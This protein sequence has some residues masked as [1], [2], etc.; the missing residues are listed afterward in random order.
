[1]LEAGAGDLQACLVPQ[2]ID[3]ELLLQLC[4]GRGQAE[5]VV[6]E[7]RLRGDEGEPV[8]THERNL[9]VGL[10]LQILHDRRVVFDEVRIRPFDQIPEVGVP[11][12]SGDIDAE[13][14]L[15]FVHRIGLDQA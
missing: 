8:R 2:R 5:N 4:L 11:A 15:R 14:R 13:H 12:E 6:V 7:R 1:M 10:R 9:G 3:T